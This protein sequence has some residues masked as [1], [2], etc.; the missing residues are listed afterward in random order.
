MS[1]LGR[2]V[3][4]CPDRVKPRGRI[5]DA[6][7]CDDGELLEARLDAARAADLRDAAGAMP[8]GSAGGAATASGSAGAAGASGGTGT[9]G[10]AGAADAAGAAGA[11]GCRGCL[12]GLR[13][14]GSTAGASGA[15]G[16]A[17]AAGAAGPGGA[18]DIDDR[19]FAGAAG[20]SAAARIDRRPARRCNSAAV[21]GGVRLVNLRDVPAFPIPAVEVGEL[22]AMLSSVP[23]ADVSDVA[24]VNMVSAWQQVLNMAEAAQA[25]VIREIEARTPDALPRVPDELACALVS[26]RRPRRPP[27]P[28]RVGRRTASRPGRRVGLRRHRRPQD[29]CRPGRDRSGGGEPVPRRDVAAVVADAVD[30]SRR[31]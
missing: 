23:V 22:A 12:E 27:V 9:A 29:R 31:R 6:R 4:L 15:S 3:V 21:S 13:R 5:D 18:A 19:W 11:C 2:P 26:T 7:W 16:G 28:A 8:R 24:L 20:L 1:V 10:A 17:S 30:H 14:H 25:Q